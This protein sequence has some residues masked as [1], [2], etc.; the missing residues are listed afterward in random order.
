MKNTDPSS[1]LEPKDGDFVAYLKKLEAGQIGTLGGLHV[2][3][4]QGDQ[5]GMVVVETTKEIVGRNEQIKA[6]RTASIDQGVTA[7]MTVSGPVLAL[8]GVVFVAAAVAMPGEFDFLIPF[9][10]VLLFFSVVLSAE[11]KK[12]RKKNNSQTN[13]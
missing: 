10:M 13:Q 11:A 9:G 6:Q 12:R 4:P 3:L 8:V 1:S 7:A 5:R 2:S